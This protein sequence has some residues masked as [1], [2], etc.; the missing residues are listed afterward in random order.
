MFWSVVALISCVKL[1]LIP[2][3]RST[4]FEV[5]RNWLAITH[6]LPISKWYL[7]DTSEWTLDYPPLFAWFER[8][9]SYIAQYFDPEMLQLKNLN[10]ASSE[11]VLFQRLSVIATD[12]V[13]AYGTYDGIRKSSKWGSRWGSPAA[14]LQILLVGNTGLLLVDHIHFQYNGFLLGLLLLSVARLLQGHCLMAA[15]WFA[16]LLNMKH[17]FMYVA[18]AYFVYLLRSYCFPGNHSG[19]SV[20]WRSFSLVRFAKLGL[21][22]ASVFLV[23]FGPFI[24]LNQLPQVFSRL[25]PFKRGLC[26]A[27]WAPNIWALYNVV[28]KIVSIIGRQLGLLSDV[29]MA[30]MTGGLVQEYKHVVLPEITPRITFLCTLLSILLWRSPGNPYHFVRCIILCACGSFMFGWHVH[31]KAILLVIIPLSL[32]AVI[33]KK[34]AQMYVLLSTVGHYSL[35]PLLFTKFELPIKVILLLLH[36]TYAFMNLASLF[37]IKKSS[38]CLPLLNVVESLYLVGLVPLFM[39]ENVVHP[40][41]GLDKRLPF[42]PLMLTSVYCA[43]GVMYF[44]LKYYWHFLTTSDLNHKRKAH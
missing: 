5:H 8:L 15:F 34:E 3:Y 30:V 7:E 10:Y 39:F 20:Q 44:W 32:M 28:D 11:T 26:H 1:L 43:I 6:S 21:V 2:S 19:S 37:D 4:D 38:L 14:I 12:L 42:L 16:V 9:L 17:I 29:P 31:E 33:W 40:W 24:L 18:P 13:F 23:S 36:S 22:V 35:F 41:L 27:Y 25:F